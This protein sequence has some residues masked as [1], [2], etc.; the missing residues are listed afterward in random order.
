MQSADF[1][2]LGGSNSTGLCSAL[3]K[4]TDDP[5][6]PCIYL[7]NGISVSVGGNLFADA[8]K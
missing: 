6:P 1:N 2:I 4:Y 7:Q 8:D 5:L 3:C